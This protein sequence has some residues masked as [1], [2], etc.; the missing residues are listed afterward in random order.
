MEYTPATLPDIETPQQQQ[1]AHSAQDHSTPG[2]DA[3]G[4]RGGDGPGEKQ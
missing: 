1:A 3:D 4:R 2:G